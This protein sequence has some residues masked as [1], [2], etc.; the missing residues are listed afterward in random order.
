MLFDLVD[1][2]FE[3]IRVDHSDQRFVE[4]FDLEWMGGRLDYGFADAS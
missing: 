2:M 1:D 4:V 3:S